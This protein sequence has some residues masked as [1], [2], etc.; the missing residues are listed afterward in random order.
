MKNNKKSFEE[1]DMER[2]KEYLGEVRAG[3]KKISS[4]AVKPHELVRQA[5]RY[6]MPHINTQL[7]NLLSC[8]PSLHL[9][10][11]QHQLHVEH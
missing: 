7:V 2:F 5:M 10:N 6:A 1:H 9:A 11:L 3:K 4:G 8:I